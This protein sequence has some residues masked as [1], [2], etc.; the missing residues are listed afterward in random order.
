ML[1]LTKSFAC[2]IA[3]AQLA[4]VLWYDSTAPF[5]ERSTNAAVAFCVGE[6]ADRLTVLL[7][8]VTRS[9]QSS[10]V[11]YRAAEMCRYP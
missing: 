7:Y 11:L 5:T 8:I 6:V 3:E 1:S 9:G 2:C 4:A 10:A